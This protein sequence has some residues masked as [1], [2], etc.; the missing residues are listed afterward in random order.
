M[1][2]VIICKFGNELEE[3]KTDNLNNISSVYGYFF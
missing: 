3:N 1:K 2:I